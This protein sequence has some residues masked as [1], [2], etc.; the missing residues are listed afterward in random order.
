MLTRQD[1]PAVP[2]T[3][4]FVHRGAVVGGIGTDIVVTPDGRRVA[5]LAGPPGGKQI[6]VRSLDRLDPVAIGPAGQLQSLSIST[7]GQWIGYVDGATRSLMKINIAGGA[8]LTVC[9]NLP[10]A[11]SSAAWGTNDLIVFA[12]SERTDAAGL[13]SVPAAGGTPQRILGPEQG[14]Q[15]LLRRPAFLPSGRTVLFDTGAVGASIDTMQVE[16]LDIESGKRTVVLRGGV[17]PQYL[18]SGHL[19]YA[20]EGAMRA[21]RFDAATLAVTG[22]PV[23]VLDGVVAEANRTASFGVSAS[24]TSAYVKGNLSPGRRSIVWVDR[25]GR[26]EAIGAPARAYAYAILS[27]DN[28]R[29]ALDARDE[30]SDIWIWHLALKTMTRL[31]LETTINRSPVWVPPDGRR[32]A[33]SSVRE[34]VEQPVWQAADG[35]SPAEPLASHPNTLL[36]KSFSPDGRWLLV[37]QGVQPFDLI[38]VDLRDTSRRPRPLLETR[39]NELNGEISPDGK[40]LAYQSNESGRYEVYVHPFPEVTNARFQVSTGGGTRPAWS[41]DGRH[42]FYSLDLTNLQDDPMSP[43]GAIV[44]VPVRADRTFGFGSATTVVKGG[45]PAPF[46]GRHYDI[47]RDGRFLMIKDARTP[48]E[49][50]APPQIVVVQNWLNELKRLVPVN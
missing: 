49:V 45:Y 7:D 21:V 39:F 50:A 4:E 42:L 3:F 27:P 40:W 1:T 33:F 23:Q 31:T 47:S 22:A 38:V 19:V 32:L 29:I 30:N 5:Y 6:Y 25:D 11:P 10:A 9:G 14:R 17:Q 24:G 34:G 2:T 46:A 8:A 12:I 44:S 20:T 41:H 16:A 35:S 26:E 48:G 37:S 15:E 36:P 28:T 18:P 13:W 43:G